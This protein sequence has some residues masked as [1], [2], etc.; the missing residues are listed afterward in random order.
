MALSLCCAGKQREE[1]ILGLRKGET[2]S[3]IPCR[4]NISRHVR[5]GGSSV[6]LK[7]QVCITNRSV[8]PLKNVVRGLA[9]RI[10]FSLYSS[11]TVIV[12][13]LCNAKCL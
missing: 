2:A 9:A 6:H 10:A 7:S 1:A 11:Y 12:K 4:V 8:N 3:D 5:P 13:K